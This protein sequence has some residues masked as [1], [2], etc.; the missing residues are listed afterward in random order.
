[1]FSRVV[2][3]WFFVLS[4]SH[5]FIFNVFYFWFS[6]MVFITF[7]KAIWNQTGCLFIKQQ[8]A[9][10]IKFRGWFSS[11]DLEFRNAGKTVIVLHL[12]VNQKSFSW[13]LYISYWSLYQSIY[14][15]IYES[16][17]QSIYQFIYQSIYQSIYW[18]SMNSSINPSIGSSINPS[19]NP[20]IQVQKTVNDYQ[21]IESYIALPPMILAALYLG[22]LSGMFTTVLR[23]T[24][25]TSN[26]RCDKR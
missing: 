18:L 4:N 3:I 9:V 19:I 11:K 25:D 2:K 24:L 14:Q 5:T 16:I 7:N 8:V 23:Q 26:S 1:M 10:E 22:P 21:V 6:S 17:Y 15:S 13:K 12:P 20:Y